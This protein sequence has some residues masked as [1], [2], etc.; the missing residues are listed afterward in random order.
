M[1]EVQNHPGSKHADSRL[2]DVVALVKRGDTMAFEELYRLTYKY[3]YFHARSILHDDNEAWDLVQETY[4]A[5]YQHIDSLREER[6]VKSWIS[7]IVFNLGMKRLRKKRDLLVDEENDFLFDALEDE[8]TDGSPEKALDSKETAAIVREVIDRLPALQKA[9]VIA[10]YFDE[11]SVSDIAREAMCSENTIKSRLNYARKAMK[12]GI[13]HKERQMGVKLHVVTGPMIVFVLRG[14]FSS[15]TVSAQKARYTWMAVRKTLGLAGMA[16]GAGSAGSA[17][18]GAAGSTGSTGGAT[19]S[20]GSAAGPA[21]SAGNAGGAAASAAGP[22]ASTAAAGAA[23]TAGSAGAA[24]LL[25]GAVKVKT[26]VILLTACLATGGAAGV[27]IGKGAIAA[28]RQETAGQSNGGSGS[29]TSQ[30]DVLSANAG[31]SDGTD[32]QAETTA[33]A[34]DLSDGWKTLD[35]NSGYG[36]MENG[37]YV[38]HT[39]KEIEGEVYYFDRNGRM[40]D[41]QISLGRQTFSFNSD[42]RLTGIQAADHGAGCTVYYDEDIRYSLDNGRLIRESPENGHL[43]LYDGPEALTGFTVSDDMAL[44]FSVNKLLLID[45]ADGSVLN[46]YPVA[47]LDITAP[48]SLCLS[49]SGL[50]LSALNSERTDGNLIKLTNLTVPPDG[51]ETDPMDNYSLENINHSYGYSPEFFKLQAA[52]GE[53]YF[54][55]SNRYPTAGGVQTSGYRLC[56]SSNQESTVLMDENV[57]EFFIH[58]DTLFY[59]AD[60]AL[61][62]KSLSQMA[63]ATTERN[64]KAL[65]AYRERLTEY[66]KIPTETTDDNPAAPRGFCAVDLNQD[67]VLEVLVERG[68]YFATQY[69]ELLYYTDHL[70]Q[71]D[72]MQSCSLVNENNGL[73]LSAIFHQDFNCTVY[74]FDGTGVQEVANIYLSPNI[75]SYENERAAAAEIT[76][77]LADLERWEYGANEI[78]GLMLNETAFDL[79]LTGDGARTSYI[80]SS[81]SPSAKEFLSPALDPEE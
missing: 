43:T 19:G 60:G 81:L 46:E 58:G 74:H 20:A 17:G 79:T 7:G 6:Y 26:A 33:P 25:F 59:M 29:P 21:G 8:N 71:A 57:D 51:Y 13:E 65:A 27:A 11:K 9:A 16:A 61:T 38:R 63:A 40:A 72:L 28:S 2:L 67:G 39:W 31:V 45:A 49:D 78:S 54:L 69:C 80:P 34:V 36:Y 48:L 50:Y 55:R 14:M 66:A 23:G 42:G 5:V 37:E 62:K 30:A 4:I 70:E 3:A 22:A 77:G 64:Q 68:Q 10:Y 75:L 12:E 41:Q 56:R 53:V 15:M 32:T 1:S 18:G 44:C 76:R 73:I 24:S 52:D 35:N 47:S